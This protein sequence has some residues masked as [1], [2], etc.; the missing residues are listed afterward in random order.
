MQPLATHRVM[1]S[2]TMS[3]RS[4]SSITPCVH[5]MFWLRSACMYAHSR[6]IIL[7]LFSLC[8]AM[9]TTLIATF[10]ALNVPA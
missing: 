6:R 10:M 5:T 3:T 4:G 7:R 1:S 9:S 8:F 2:M